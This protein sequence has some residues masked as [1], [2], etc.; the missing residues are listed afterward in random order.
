MEQSPSSPNF[1]SAR[2]CHRAMDP[3]SPQ[4]ANPSSFTFLVCIILQLLCA[5]DLR[6]KV[7]LLP[8]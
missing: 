2:D 8:V 4:S 7:R 6:K 1:D 3:P 5:C